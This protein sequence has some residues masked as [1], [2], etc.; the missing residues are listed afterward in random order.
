MSTLFAAG[1][2]AFLE[3]GPGS[4]LTGLVKR[5]EPRAQTAHVSDRETL[6]ALR[7]DGRYLE[8]A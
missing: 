6:R 8:D 4:V 2:D 5:I 7:D 3:V 1:Y